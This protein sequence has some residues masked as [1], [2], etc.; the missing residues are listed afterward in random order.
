MKYSIIFAIL[1]SLLMG[2]CAFLSSNNIFI[3]LA[4]FAIYL[5]Y[6]FIFVSK[7]LKKYS[8]KLYRIHHCYHFINSFL[9]AMSVR[10][11]LEEAYRSGVQG[12]DGELK[13]IVE[14]IDNM[15]VNERLNYLRKYFNLSIYRLFL[16]VVNLYLDQGGNILDMANSLVAESTR[17]EDSVN[18]ASKA[19]TKNVL[20]FVI[21]WVIS[22]GVL[23][24][25]RFGISQFYVSMLKSPLF[26]GMLVIYFLLILLSI[27]FLIS[28]A[29]ELFIKEDN[30]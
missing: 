23:L 20:E 2:V 29:T 19:V 5:A 10:N 15:E 28:K 12:A 16:N 4:I 3:A 30:L 17:I 24:F 11:S 7:K 9:I 1:V 13:S 6:Y 27:H 26:L 25:M 18:K 21:L 14:E 22:V 8:Q